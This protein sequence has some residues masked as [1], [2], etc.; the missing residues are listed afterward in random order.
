MSQTFEPRTEWEA[1][2]PTADAG[3][4]VDRTFSISGHCRF[5]LDNPCGRIRVVGSDQSQ[6]EL[7]ATRR[8]NPTS[9]RYQATRVETFQEG[10]TI[11]VRTVFDPAA[12][13]AERG[14]LGGV[15]AEMLHV[16]GELIR[17]INHPCEVEYE[18]RVPRRA[19]LDLKGVSSSIALRGVEGALRARSVSGNITG[20]DLA[21]DLD[22]GSVSGEIRAHVLV[23]RLAIES[24]SGGMEVTGD[25]RAVRAKTVS[26]AITIASPL[27]SHGTYDL[28]SVSGDA[29]LRV[30]GSTGATV[31]AR[32]MSSTVSCD[33]PCQIIRNRTGPGA[34]AWQGIVNGGGATV[35]FQ[36]VSGNLR[37]GELNLPLAT[38][39]PPAPAEPTR[40]DESVAPSVETTATAEAPTVPPIPTDNDAT[41]MQVLKELER[42]DMSVDEAL[43][44]LESLRE[45]GDH[46]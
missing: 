24:V 42:G 9:A 35:S 20:E 10:D 28:H 2:P 8:G 3:A 23:G 11:S 43:R 6:V 14:T 45:R 22:L 4:S 5:S 1:E 44:R 18:V 30:P 26:G 40:P 15:A 13:F 39:Q 46:A 37:L 41:T 7:R 29:T 33:L 27:Q 19:D 34:R 21:G 17:P 12:A 38:P 32:S 25:L 31:S 16:V 36:S